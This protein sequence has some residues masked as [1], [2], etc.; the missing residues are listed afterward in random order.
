METHRKM[1]QRL[2]LYKPRIASSHQRK[3]RGTEWI[4]LQGLQERQTLPTPRF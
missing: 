4:L 1:G 2:A 3:A